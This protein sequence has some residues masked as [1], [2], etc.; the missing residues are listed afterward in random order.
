[1]RLGTWS[2]LEQHVH[3]GSSQVLVCG[4]G[5]CGLEAHGGQAGRRVL[6]TTAGSADT[7]WLC[8]VNGPLS[9]PATLPPL[10][11]LPLLI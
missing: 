4:L 11:T 2:H 10:K 1:M 8:W 6:R 5:A 7:A 3:Q 9:M